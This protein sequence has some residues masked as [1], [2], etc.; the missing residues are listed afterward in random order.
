MNQKTTTEDKEFNFIENFSSCALA[1]RK[2][3][4]PGLY[5]EAVLGLIYLRY[6]NELYDAEYRLLALERVPRVEQRFRFQRDHIPW[7]PPQARWDYIGALCQAGENP[8]VI[9]RALWLI[10]EENPELGGLVHRIYSSD[11]LDYG[12]IRSLI[13]AFR[14]LRISHG[15]SVRVFFA[16]LFEKTLSTLSSGSEYPVQYRAF[17]KIICDDV[18]KIKRGRILIPYSGTAWVLCRV[19]AYI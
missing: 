17:S 16:A 10:E 5:R 8:S 11:A 9:D 15:H 3:Q 6:L 12:A 14:R 1:L 2:S 13:L 18:V 4:N 19:A 7:L